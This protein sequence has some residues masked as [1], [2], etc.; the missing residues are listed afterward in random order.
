MHELMGGCH[1]GN[2]SVV[3]KTAVAPEDAEPRA[4]QCVFC[5]KHNT[6]AISDPAGDLT[7]T[8]GAGEKL[9]RYRFGLRTADF[10]VCRECG[11]YI[12][13]F[14]H[15]A[16]ENTGFATLMSA[17]LDERAR[18]AGGQAIS[19]SAEDKDG[20]LARRRKVWTPARLQ[21]G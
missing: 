12:G 16:D 21:V 13:A 6:S 10:L 3:Y 7:I 2:I 17:V 18:Y 11:V 5:R 19:F 9:S 20:R 4:C 14:M 1:C 8:V 15:G